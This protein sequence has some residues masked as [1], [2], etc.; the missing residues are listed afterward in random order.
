MEQNVL[1]PIKTDEG[2]VKDKQNIKE[3][4]AHELSDKKFAPRKQVK[5]ERDVFS[6]RIY[7]DFKASGRRESFLC[8]RK[9]ITLNYD[10]CL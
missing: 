3:N 8:Y 4:A 10:M 1:A 9:I 5:S 7:K 2:V 6:P